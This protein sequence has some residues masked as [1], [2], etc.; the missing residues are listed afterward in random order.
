[1]FK[2][3]HQYSL[4]MQTV[5]QSTFN[6]KKKLLLLLFLIFIFSKSHHSWKIM[7][8][9][10]VGYSHQLLFAKVSRKAYFFAYHHEK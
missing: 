3:S 6:Q 10:G 2:I 7:A 1:M 5:A 4:H 8:A 9:E